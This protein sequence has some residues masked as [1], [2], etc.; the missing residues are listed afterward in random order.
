MTI[1]F[2]SIT[3]AIM[4]TPAA[5]SLAVPSVPGGTDQM[6]VAA[7]T[8]YTDG[9]SPGTTEV[10]N[11]AGGGLTWALIAGTESCSGRISQPR[12]SLWWAFGSPSSFTATVTF[13]NNPREFGA[14]VSV[15][16]T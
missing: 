6:Y 1:A 8:L 3:G 16:R 12:Q 5:G 9:G 15:S 11:I 4:T 13:K 7:V 14:N 10:D 2:E